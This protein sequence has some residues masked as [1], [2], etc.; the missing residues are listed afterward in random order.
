[1]AGVG[2]ENL[3]SVI[4]AMASELDSL[5]KDDSICRKD[6]LDFM[7]AN[8]WFGIS[9][10]I[11]DRI[12]MIEKC[13][14]SRF[15]AP[16]TLWLSAYRKPARDKL[17]LM[18]QHFSP[19]YPETCS[20]YRDFIQDKHMEDEPSAWK[21]LDF[22]LSETDK[23]ITAYSEADLEALVK[24]MSVHTTRAAARLFTEFLQIAK[25]RGKPLTQWSYSFAPRN[26][27]ALV[28]DA[29][30]IDDFA[31]MAY[32]IFN[33]EMW[34]QQKLV[35]KAVQ[36]PVY[37][38]LWLFFAFNFICAL[39]KNDIKRLPAPTL[40]Y[41][42]DHVFKM[43]ANHS[44]P[45]EDALSLVEELGIRLKLKPMKPSK[46]ALQESISDLVIFVPESLK[47][48]LGLIMA[49]SLAHHPG[50]CAGDGFIRPLDELCVIR[51]FF[52]ERFVA[53]L[54]NRR[55]SSR[56]SNKSY[57]QGIDSIGGNCGAY[58][59]PKGYMLAALARSHKSGIATLAKT[60]DVYLKD[61]RFSG[62]RPEFIIQQMFERGVFGFIPAVLL[63]MYAGAD[64][65]A[66]PITGQTELICGLG[67]EAHQIERM[68]YMVHSALLKSR[69]AVHEVLKAPSNIQENTFNMLQNI[70]SGNAP[71][72]Q[73]EYLCLMTAAGFPCANT[74]RDGCIGCGYEIYT[75]TAMHTL[76]KEYARLSK[77][78]KHSNKSD[79]WRY[80]QILK[81]AILPAVS[82][83][84][85]SMRLLYPQADTS[86]LLDIIEEGLKYGDYSIHGN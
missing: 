84:L 43:I 10:P 6:V 33:E 71:S 18:L 52:G 77:L 14:M 42:A 15:E 61:A 60:T 63:E 23:E 46:T 41:S 56:R 24:Q 72:R 47:E 75:K 86:G 34:A 13:T 11:Q 55:F 67:L 51:K 16:L 12:P 45:R 7:E 35:E 49:I 37:A 32:H 36:S 69:K 74:D 9:C 28:N 50:I 82:E 22:I 70:A 19:I 5:Y 68:A 38:D 44:F 8:E 27:P 29:Y 54:G 79:A 65:I 53:A 39:R 57:L 59:K 80:E 25:H 62:Y 76:I 40:P 78:R 26:L 21:L 73:R 3:F 85:S 17:A 20:I 58:G 66:L 81:C 30:P 83:M 48:P 31:V 2:S 1:M 64:Y 4:A